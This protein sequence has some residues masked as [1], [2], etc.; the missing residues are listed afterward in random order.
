MPQPISDIVA[1]NRDNVRNIRFIINDSNLT[2][3]SNHN[4]FQLNG[5][6][7]IIIL[8][9]YFA[10]AYNGPIPV[11]ENDDDVAYNNEYTRIER[12]NRL[13]THLFR[14]G[15]DINSINDNSPQ[16]LTI[17]SNNDSFVADCLNFTEGC[18][19]DALCIQNGTCVNIMNDGS[20]ALRGASANNYYHQLRHHVSSEYYTLTTTLPQVTDRCI[21]EC[22]NCNI[23]GGKK[24]KSKRRKRKQNKRKSKKR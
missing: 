3:I 20:I 12:E 19:R 11:D 4:I 7:N 24:R 16:L 14:N 6:N 23:S 21:T 1:N 15:T 2:Y 9:E 22:R 18:S 5:N 8:G 10:S 17:M 13:Y